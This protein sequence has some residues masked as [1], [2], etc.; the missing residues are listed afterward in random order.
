MKKLTLLIA[1][2]LCVTIGGVYATWLYPGQTVAPL[3]TSLSHEMAGVEFTGSSGSYA[4]T[5][6]SLVINIDQESTDSFNAVLAFGGSVTITFTAHERISAE[7]LT[8]A[9]TPTITVTAT[10]LDAAVY[11]G[12]DIYAVDDTFSFTL[13][14]DTDW[15]VSGNVYTCTID[16]S[17]L[18][19]AISL[20]NTFTL[21]N[22][23]KYQNFKTAQ[24]HAVFRVVV[25]AATVATTN[26]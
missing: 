3:S 7:A 9:L 11:E 5:A 8:A 14:K 6:N 23:T 25:T 13:D 18:Q 21:N 1:L 16:A 17:R 12:K 24:S 2:I 10:D 15:T 20:A 19:G 22:Y 4:A 26:P